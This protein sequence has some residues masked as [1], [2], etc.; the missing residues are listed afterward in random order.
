MQHNGPKYLRE[1]SGQVLDALVASVQAKASDGHVSVETLRGI[2]QALKT[3]PEFDAFY[4]QAYNTVYEAMERQTRIEQRRNALG[5]LMV[6]PLAGLLNDE[7]LSRE[8]L[9]NLFHFFQLSLGDQLAHYA[10]TCNEVLDLVIAEQGEAFAWDDFYAHPDARIVQA[11]VLWTIVKTFR[12]FEG[13]RDWFIKLMQYHPS[14]ISLGQHMFINTPRPP[15]GHTAPPFGHGEFQVLLSALVSPLANLSTADKAM[16][17]SA[18]DDFDEDQ[19]NAFLD[20]L[21]G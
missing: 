4:Q 15:E 5:R 2:A 17:H 14:S 19:L 10:E 21:Q 20:K 6:H 7:T 9:P 18:L 1:I 12:N 8:H 13:R 16:L 3:S 11:K